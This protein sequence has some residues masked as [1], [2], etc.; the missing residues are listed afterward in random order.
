MKGKF[1][2]GQETF[3]KGKEMAE[4]AQEAANQIKDL[5]GQLQELKEALK[6]KDAALEM[7]KSKGIE[8]LT[9]GGEEGGVE[10]PSA[11][12]SLVSYGVGKL[13]GA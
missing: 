11:I 4:K 12:S 6:D 10:E 13:T 8:A 2:K 5:M 7:L 3:E 9:G 1:A